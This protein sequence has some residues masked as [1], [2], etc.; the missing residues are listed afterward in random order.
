LVVR[1]GGDPKVDATP[2]VLGNASP[3]VLAS[4]LPS[5]ERASFVAPYSDRRQSISLWTVSLGLNRPAREFG[6]HRYSTFVQPPWLKSLAQMRE[7]AAVMS[8]E[9]RERIPPYVF[10]GYQQIDSGLNDAAPFLVSFCGTDR[11][12]NWSSLGRN[13]KTDKKNHW[14]DALI[15]DIDRQ[16][17]GIASAVMHREMATAETMLR[18]LNTPGGAVYGFAPVDS[19]RQTIKRGPQ[20]PIRG[21]WLASAYTVSGGYTGA[22]I[23]GAQAASG[24]MRH[25]SRGA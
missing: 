4:L 10:V 3:S 15:A 8:E 21:L 11:I 20:T 24:A 18:Y 25:R 5:D 2:I 6:V 13:A 17:P 9:P 7:A 1:D 14:I 23:G 12:E 19:L 16:F 22:M